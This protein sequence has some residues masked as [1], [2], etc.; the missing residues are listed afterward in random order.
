MAKV[1]NKSRD[2]VMVAMSV[3][4][5]ASLL[6]LEATIKQAANALGCCM[7]E[8]TRKRFDTDDSPIKVYQ[9]PYGVVE[10]ECYVEQ[11]SRGGRGSSAGATPLFARQISHNYAQ[12]IAR[13][14]HDGPGVEPWSQGG[15]FVHPAC[16]QVGGRYCRS[17]RRSLGVRA[18]PASRRH[19][20]RRREPRRA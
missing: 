12:L 3:L 20:H 10:A 18:A 19:R 11:T 8:D 2:E 16:G 6:E 9:T 17:R 13:A 14:V 5:G 1:L 15:Y 4:L 7:T